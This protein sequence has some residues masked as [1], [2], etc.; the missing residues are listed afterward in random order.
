MCYRKGGDE[1][2]LDVIVVVSP[3]H[4]GADLKQWLQ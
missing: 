2:K 4:T 1:A 3:V